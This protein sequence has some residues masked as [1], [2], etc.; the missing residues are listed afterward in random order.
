MAAKANRRA[1]DPAAL[2]AS[3]TERSVNSQLHAPAQA[4][5]EFHPLAEIFPLIEGEDFKALVED[6]RAH[7]LHEPIVVHEDSILDGRN[8]YRACIAAG[9]EPTFTPYPRR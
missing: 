5:L 2:G 1:G 6:I 7:G 9:V 3:T 8:R 4:D